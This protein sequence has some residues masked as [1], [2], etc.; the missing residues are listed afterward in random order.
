MLRLLSVAFQCCQLHRYLAQT[1]QRGDIADR[2]GR[3]GVLLYRF[4][5]DIS[6]L[7]PCRLARNPDDWHPGSFS[8]L[9]GLNAIGLAATMADNDDCIAAGKWSWII[10]KLESA[11][12]PGIDSNHA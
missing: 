5:R 9:D 2:V 6:P 3:G 12:S 10:G 11:Q 8:A 7:H 4:Q 1:G